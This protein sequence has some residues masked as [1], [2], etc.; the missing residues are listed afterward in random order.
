MAREIKAVIELTK[1]QT[2]EFL[3]NFASPESEK[4][5]RQAVERASKIKFNVVL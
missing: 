1:K 4:L 2:R 5:G 3:D